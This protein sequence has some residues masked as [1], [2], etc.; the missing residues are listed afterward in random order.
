MKD[1]ALESERFTQ[2]EVSNGAQSACCFVWAWSSCR[3]GDVGY[4]TRSHSEVQ[5]SLAG[6]HHQQ[7]R[8]A[9]DGSAQEHVQ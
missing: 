8:P 9:F 6:R 1:M 2:L 5:G 3:H 4:V 7:H